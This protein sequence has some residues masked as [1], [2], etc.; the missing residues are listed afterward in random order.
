MPLYK[1]SLLNTIDAIRKY[2]FILFYIERPLSDVSLV[3][4]LKY[5]MDFRRTSQ[6]TLYSR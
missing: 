4:T 1:M 3:I 6:F 5:F 2:H